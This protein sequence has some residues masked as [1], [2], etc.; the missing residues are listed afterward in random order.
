[1]EVDDT[2]DGIRQGMVVMA[3]FTN[4]PDD[5]K[6]MAEKTTAGIKRRRAP[7]LRLPG[8]GPE[9]QEVECKG[10]K[11]LADEPDPQHELVRQG[12]RRQG[13]E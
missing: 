10:G 8:R 4:M 12:H 5:V 2:W 6:A 11:T 9:R 7:S 1:M 3:P 13:A